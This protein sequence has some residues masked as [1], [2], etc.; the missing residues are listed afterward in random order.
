[1]SAQGEVYE[2]RV[3]GHL[4]QH[5]ATW[6]GCTDL[7]HSDGT[8]TLRTYPSTSP[9]CTAFSRGSGTQVTS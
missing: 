5:W 1:V 4:D 3:R 8:T 2:I 6:S 9:N 7:V